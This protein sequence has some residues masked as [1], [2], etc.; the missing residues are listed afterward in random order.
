MPWPQL[1]LVNHSLFYPS[2]FLS[3]T[4]FLSCPRVN[5]YYVLH[6]SH[7]LTTQVP[8]THAAP[9][10]LLL[11]RAAIRHAVAPPRFVWVGWWGG[12]SVAFILL[13]PRGWLMN[14][15][16]AFLRQLQSP[17]MAP[18]KGSNDDGIK[19]DVRIFL[20]FLCDLNCCGFV[21]LFLGVPAWQLLH[22]KESHC[23]LR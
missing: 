13:F 9:D 2:S 15:F 12:C 18:S 11:R 21:S 4:S 17:A 1:R 23:C 7:L 16:E 3:L 8:M 19:T 22:M 6:G 14:I 5:R 10:L 20:F